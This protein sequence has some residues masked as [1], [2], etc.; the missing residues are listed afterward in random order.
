MNKSLITGISLICLFG[1][2]GCSSPNNSVTD[3]QISKQKEVF[4]QAPTIQHA[5]TVD[6][7]IKCEEFGKE[8][9]KNMYM[10]DGWIEFEFY[11]SPILDTCIL[12]REEFG[13]KPDMYVW[14]LYDMFTKE[15]LLY[16][17]TFEGIGC[18]AAQEC[19]DSIEQYKFK[20]DKMLG[21]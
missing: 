17:A 20:K 7:K 19:V 5:S 18:S 3:I 13:P 16:Y 21:N 9:Y 12:Q 2:L 4:T 14:K 11:Y 1:L 8:T 15:I 6:Q 10:D